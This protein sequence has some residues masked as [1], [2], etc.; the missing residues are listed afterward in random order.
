MASMASK[1]PDLDRWAEKNL[2]SDHLPAND[3]WALGD[4]VTAIRCANG[5]TVVVNHDHSVP[6]PYSKMFRVQGTER[7]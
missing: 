3:D 6:R 1:S 2:G 5:E 4:I 7:L